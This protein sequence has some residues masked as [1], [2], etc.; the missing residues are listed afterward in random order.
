MVE[1]GS[2]VE[3]L[4]DVDCQYLKR[5]LLLEELVTQV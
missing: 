3:S 5:A 4:H 1:R 2:G